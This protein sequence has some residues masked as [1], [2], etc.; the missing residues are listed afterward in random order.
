MRAALYLS[1]AAGLW[2][3]C[4]RARSAEPDNPAVQAAASELAARVLSLEGRVSALEKLADHAVETG[5]IAA[6][7][8]KL[9]YAEAHARALT[10]G[11][12]LVVWSGAAVCPACVHDTEGEFVNYVGV[13]PGLAPDAVS[14][15][16][17]EGGTLH[18]AG[19][20]AWWMTG[21]RTFGHVP[22]VRRILANWRANRVVH[23]QA[24]PQAYPGP[25]MAQTYGSAFGV[26]RPLAQRPTM[27]FGG[28]RGG[29]CATCR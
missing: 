18:A 13:V 14:V 2:A 5:A 1:L 9:T 22:S 20:V 3:G 24:A 28:V 7:D 23:R 15:Y 19:D 29:A 25:M 8:R 26:G 27:L 17:P 4:T 16:V 6:P 12:P 10:E 11:K 21:D